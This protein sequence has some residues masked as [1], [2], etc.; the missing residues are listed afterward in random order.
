M[1]SVTN[2]ILKVVAK[3][4]QLMLSE[5]RDIFLPADGLLLVPE[6]LGVTAEE[7]VCFPSKENASDLANMGAPFSAACDALHQTLAA[8]IAQTFSSAGFTVSDNGLLEI[9]ARTKSLGNSIKGPP[10]GCSNTISNHDLMT[11]SRFR[12]REE[13]I[14]RIEELCNTFC[15]RC[16]DGIFLPER[17][18]GREGMTRPT[19]CIE[20]IMDTLSKEFE[21]HQLTGA[22]S[23]ATRHMAMFEMLLLI[24]PIYYEKKLQMMHSSFIM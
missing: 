6:R 4:G 21:H 8:P 15:S 11:T 24:F 7:L 1:S 14:N 18:H 22:R 13:V 16:G 20:S 3:D 9:L 10:T 17:A 2:I 12:L 19:W 5:T 23:A